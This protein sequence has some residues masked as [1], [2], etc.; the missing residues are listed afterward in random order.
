MRKILKFYCFH[1]VSVSSWSTW[2]L[3]RGSRLKFDA[4]SG[5]R[6]SNDCQCRSWASTRIESFHQ[7]VVQVSG[8]GRDSRKW[9]WEKSWNSM[10]EHAEIGQRLPTPLTSINQDSII[11]PGHWIQFSSYRCRPGRDLIKQWK[12]WRGKNHSCMIWWWK[13]A[14]GHKP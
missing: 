4:W 8:L 14:K 1:P 12:W 11:P 6:Q 7:A 5:Q 9:K 13:M 10:H 3:G 2:G